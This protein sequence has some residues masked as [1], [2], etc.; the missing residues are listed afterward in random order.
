M[1]EDPNKHRI[2]TRKEVPKLLQSGLVEIVAKATAHELKPGH[3]YLVCMPMAPD[4]E[5]RAINRQLKLIGINAMIV[6]L[7]AERG[8]SVEVFEMLTE[9][10][11]VEAETKR[12]SSP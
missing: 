6:C 8:D 5:V 12:R 9:T 11:H 3:F 10:G 4:R 1:P 7:D 2:D